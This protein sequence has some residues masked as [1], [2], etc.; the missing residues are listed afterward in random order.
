M[1][2]APAMDEISTYVFRLQLGTRNSELPI[3]AVRNIIFSV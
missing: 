3:P 1:L 2:S